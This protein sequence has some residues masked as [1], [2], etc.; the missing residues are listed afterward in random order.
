MFSGDLTSFIRFIVIL[1]LHILVVEVK[2]SRL[3]L[4]INM[5]SM[6]YHNG[7]VIITIINQ[8]SRKFVVIFYLSIAVPTPNWL[9]TYDTNV[10]HLNLKVKSVKN[11]PAEPFI[12]RQ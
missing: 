11:K 5:C 2:S 10:N 9:D 1:E 8:S 3:D 6:T 12:N 7:T 4:Q